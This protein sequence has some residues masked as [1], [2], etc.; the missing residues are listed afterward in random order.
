MKRLARFGVRRGTSALSTVLALA[1]AVTLAA[2]AAA[3]SGLSSLLDRFKDQNPRCGRVF[4]VTTQNQLLGLGRIE[5]LGNDPLF[6]LFTGTPNAVPIRTH[7]AVTGLAA[8]ETLRGIDFRPAN[9]L[10]YGLGRIGGDSAGQLYTIDLDTGAVAPV[11]P[12][13]IPLNGSGFGFD[14]NPVPDRLRIVSDTGQSMRIN[15]N[16]GTVSATDGALAYPAAGDPNSGRVARVVSVAY[17]NPDTD[18]QTNTV[19]H[20]LD[21]GRA[22]EPDRD[23]DVLAI[24][25]PPNA[26]TLN[27]VGALRIDAS[28]VGGFDIG[29]RN[30][31]LAAILPEGGGSSK[32]YAIDLPSG[33]AWE[34]GEIV[35]RQVV[36]GL[37]IGLGPLCVEAQ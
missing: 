36:T 11:G 16:D 7:R 13:A 2:P 33:G 29:P 5:D 17:T 23:G 10:L 9:G 28:D 6:E 3:Q 30:E 26:G 18:P 1:A 21:I 4:V 14:F 25:V 19:L 22:A 15:P 32:L 34:I 37:A 20:D 8:G 31:A 24:Q 35:P 27:T 12:R